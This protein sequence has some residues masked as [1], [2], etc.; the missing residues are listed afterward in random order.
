MIVTS[1]GSILAAAAATVPSSF[2]L[3]AAGTV[4]TLIGEV[5]AAVDQ[6]GVRADSRSGADHGRQ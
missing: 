6:I 3:L 2:G 4:V 5:G 1:D